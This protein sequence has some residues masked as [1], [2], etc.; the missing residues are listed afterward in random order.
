MSERALR[1]AKR[2]AIRVVICFVISYA[3]AFR[4][5]ECTLA[6]IG[7]RGPAKR[8]DA[9]R[10][11]RYDTERVLRRRCAEKGTSRTGV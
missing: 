9:T 10:A 8:G 11:L 1:W 6:V 7:T 2:F 4:G 3:S 5:A